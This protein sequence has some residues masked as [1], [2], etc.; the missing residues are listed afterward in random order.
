M[1]RLR[2]KEDT[3]SSEAK[4]LSV[5][6]VRMRSI[7]AMVDHYKDA[8]MNGSYVTPSYLIDQADRLA[9]YILNGRAK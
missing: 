7:E 1:A 8:R 3:M 9:S 2:T 6:E 5:E 4:T